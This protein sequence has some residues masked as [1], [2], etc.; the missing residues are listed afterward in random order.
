[1][2][3]VFGQVPV[4][5]RRT[6]FSFH[7]VRR[8]SNSG[9][10]IREGIVADQRVQR[11]PE[12]LRPELALGLVERLRLVLDLEFRSANTNRYL[13]RVNRLTYSATGTR[14]AH[15][16]R[17]PRSSADTAQARRLA[18]IRYATVVDFEKNLLDV[19]GLAGCRIIPPSSS[20]RRSS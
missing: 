12:P 7:D 19:R 18:A 11:V 9:L 17:Y 13:K 14:R 6:I 2:C 5:A 4:G 1:L 16:R 20:T 3:D 10:G 15:R 8:L